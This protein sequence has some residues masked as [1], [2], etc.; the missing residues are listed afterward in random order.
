MSKTLGVRPSVL[1]N[2]ED[3]YTSYCF[4]EVC[5]YIQL[6]LENGEEIIDKKHFKTF[7]EMYKTYNLNNV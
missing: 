5:V 7:S 6:R 3:E 4:D 2:L 1:F